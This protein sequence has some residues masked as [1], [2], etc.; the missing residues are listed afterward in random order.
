MFYYYINGERGDDKGAA[1][2]LQR[3]Q[4]LGEDHG[5]DGHGEDGLGAEGEARRP[6]SDPREREELQD[7]R[8]RVVAGEIDL[9]AWRAPK[10]R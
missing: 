5:G 8:R 9:P 4:P 1:G 10:P 3:P 6:R 2:I 7:V